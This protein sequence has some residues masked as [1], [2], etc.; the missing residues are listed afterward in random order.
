MRQSIIIADDF[1]DNPFEVRKIAL[2]ENYPIPADGHTYPGRNSEKPHYTTEVHEKLKFL[3][4][5][6][7]LRAADGSACG[8]FRIS[9]ETDTHE[10]D[11]HIDPGWDWGGVLFLNLPHQVQE[12]SGTSFWR[13]KK[14]NI[15]RCPE[16]PEQG[17]QLGYYDYQEI[18]QSLIHE[19]G[20]DRSKWERYATAQ[21]KYN[22]LVLFDPK[23]WHSHGMN[24]GS[25]INSGR[26]VQLFFLRN[27]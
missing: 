15:D 24:F 25:S 19:D 9:L 26:L 20:N 6:P 27:E 10:Q 8:F 18:Y 17:R 2:Q 13:H 4:G 11:V 22:R 7:K 3:T 16:N 21:M 1:Y 12:D 23:L 14:L 5:Q